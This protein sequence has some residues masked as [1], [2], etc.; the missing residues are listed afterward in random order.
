MLRC[1][2]DGGSIGFKPSAQLVEQKRVA[3]AQVVKPPAYIGLGTLSEPGAD[4][5][6][7]GPST[8]RSWA[9]RDPARDQPQLIE[10]GAAA[11]RLAGAERQRH[12]DR[13]VLHS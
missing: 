8:Q 11:F 10:L 6:I 1:V 5:F 12:Q 4:D 13:L 2:H 3:R 9:D 7:A